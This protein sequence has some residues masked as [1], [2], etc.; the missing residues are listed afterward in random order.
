MVPPERGCGEH[1]RVVLDE[2][3]MRREGSIRHDVAQVA[4]LGMARQEGVP[5]GASVVVD[6]LDDGRILISNVPSALR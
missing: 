6:C 5:E 3:V 2:G 1:V 4:V